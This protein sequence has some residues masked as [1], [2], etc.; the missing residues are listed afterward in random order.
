VLGEA[1]RQHPRARMLSAIRGGRDDR[2]VAD[3]LGRQALDLSHEPVPVFARHRDVADDRI[4]SHARG[5]RDTVA[6]VVGGR[7]VRAARGQRD[8]EE[9]QHVRVVVDDEHTTSREDSLQRRRPLGGRLAATTRAPAIRRGRSLRVTDVT[10]RGLI[11]KSAGSGRTCCRE[12]TG[13]TGHC[14]DY[15]PPRGSV[16]R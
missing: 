16:K 6:R 14:R 12:H 15:M 3:D 10:A 1:G 4:R 13:V 7:H 9:L 5:E 8:R 2:N 11:G